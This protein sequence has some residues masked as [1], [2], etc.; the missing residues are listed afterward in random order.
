MLA[1]LLPNKRVLGLLAALALLPQVATITHA[2]GC[3][4]DLLGKPLF[5]SEPR[6]LS[7]RK[8]YH[9]DPSSFKHLAEPLPIGEHSLAAK[10][11]ELLEDLATVEAELPR[12]RDFLAEFAAKN[13][14]AATVLEVADYVYIQRNKIIESFRR[15]KSKYQEL[16][17][18]EVAPYFESAAINLDFGEKSRE[19]FEARVTAFPDQFSAEFSFDR[20]E[21]R[22]LVSSLISKN[23]GELGELEQVFKINHAIGRG[24]HFAGRDKLSEAI[25]KVVRATFERLALELEQNPTL[26]ETIKTNYPIMFSKVRD[27]QAPPQRILEQLDSWVRSKEIDVICESP[28][29]GRIVWTEVKNLSSPMDLRAL[30][31][32][33]EGKSYFEQLTETIELRDFLGLKDQID[34]AIIYS[35][36]VTSEV[37]TKLGLLNIRV[38]GTVVDL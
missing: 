28:T 23:Q 32:E 24:M 3:N 6:P 25:V 12:V 17:Y 8:R 11:P 2:A 1:G 26:I 33:S 5:K 22:N 31:D 20:P 15:L 19:K 29:T 36:G 27:K 18:T 34:I 35:G 16:G 14:R 21:H 9:S 30:L 38:L 10:Y 4:D 7:G 37:K 13:S